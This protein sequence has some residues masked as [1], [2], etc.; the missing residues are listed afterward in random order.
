MESI[1]YIIYKLI[2]PTNSEIR[3]I[4]LTFNDLKQRLKSH[5]NEKAKS[6]KC[7]WIKKLKS[8]GF[9]PIIECVE[10]NISSYEIA[11]E[12]E[13]YFIDYFRSIGCDLTNSATGG[14][15]NK[16]MSDEVREKMKQAQI[17]RHKSY[18]LI[19]SEDVKKILSQKSKDRFKNSKEREKLR[20]ANK[21]YED[22]KTED[23]K[24]KDILIQNPK[25]VY[26]YDLNMIFIR[27][28]ESIKMAAQLTECNGNGISACCKG[29][30]R[31]SGGFIW[32][33]S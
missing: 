2:D 31:T 17:E 25:K 13:I 14:N 8:I 12:R 32:K 20:I 30:F 5:R 16:K 4:G 6:H 28:Y 27:E 21:I 1:K 18:K 19:H 9:D 22:S 33:Y 3:Y 26:Q 11:C 29:K 10:E 15:K 7:Y 24:L 23:Q